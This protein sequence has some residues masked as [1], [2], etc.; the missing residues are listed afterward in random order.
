VSG[1]PVLECKYG[2]SN[3]QYAVRVEKFLNSAE[4]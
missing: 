4:G 3:G 1:V 2:V